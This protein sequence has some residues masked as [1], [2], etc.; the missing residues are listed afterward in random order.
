MFS[1]TGKPSYLQSF[2]HPAWVPT[3]YMDGS[4]PSHPTTALSMKR[5]RK[6]KR[7]E[8]D[9]TVAN[10]LADLPKIPPNGDDGWRKQPRIRYVIT[11]GVQTDLK[12]IDLA[13]KIEQLEEYNMALRKKVRKLEKKVKSSEG[14]AK[15]MSKKRNRKGELYTGL[16]SWT[17]HIP[18]SALP[19]L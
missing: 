10:P 17:A 13:K 14:A 9:E 3:L 11:R 15:K 16:P 18:C 19:H 1:C 8:A 12:Q 7:K 4:S 5:S 6:R 2:D